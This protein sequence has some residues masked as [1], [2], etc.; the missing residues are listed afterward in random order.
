MRQVDVAADVGRDSKRS[1]AGEIKIDDRD[2]TH[3]PPEDRDIAMVFQNYAFYPHMSGRGQRGLRPQD[4]KAP[5]TENPT[6][7]G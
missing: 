5:K 3:L 6:A 2:V 1:T 7:G 4:A